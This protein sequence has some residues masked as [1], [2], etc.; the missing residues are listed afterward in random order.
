MPSIP[1]KQ[2]DRDRLISTFQARART[3]QRP[4]TVPAQFAKKRSLPAARAF[5]KQ[6]VTFKRGGT[7]PPP[8]ITEDDPR[9]NAATMGNRTGWHR[10]SWYER[11]RKTRGVRNYRKSSGSRPD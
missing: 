1:K 2:K 7:T 3:S 8:R 9:W 10:G 6:A 5:A 4:N 11:G